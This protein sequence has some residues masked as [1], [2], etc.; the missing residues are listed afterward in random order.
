[1]D[2]ALYERPRVMIPGL[3]NKVL[4]AK[5]VPTNDYAYHVC[6]G[7]WPILRA[8]LSPMEHL[9]QLR[10]SYYILEYGGIFAV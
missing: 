9:K 5:N 6:R 7:G 3:L 8:A 10:T 1:M 2:I 4:D